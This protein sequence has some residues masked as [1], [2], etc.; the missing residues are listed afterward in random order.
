MNSGVKLTGNTIELHEGSQQ[1]RIF[2]PPDPF[3]GVRI[4]PGSFLWSLII[5]IE[6]I[7]MSFEKA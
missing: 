5:R 3:H 4:K 6:E 7:A 1:K 2:F